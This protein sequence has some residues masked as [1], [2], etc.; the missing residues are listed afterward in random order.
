MLHKPGSEYPLPSH[1]FNVSARRYWIGAFIRIAI[2][3]LILIA[4]LSTGVP[5]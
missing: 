5:R 3:S 2:L 4:M 1:N